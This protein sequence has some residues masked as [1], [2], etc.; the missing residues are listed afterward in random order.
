VSDFGTVSWIENMRPAWWSDWGRALDAIGVAPLPGDAPF[1]DRPR[2]VLAQGT[3]LAGTLDGKRIEVA[4][5]AQVTVRVPIDPPLDLG[6]SIDPQGVF[7]SHARPTG[8]EAFDALCSILADEPTRAGALVTRPVTEAFMEL[9][10]RSLVVTLR[11]DVVTV[12]GESEG[13]LRM[14]VPLAVEVVHRID[15]GRAKLAV[16]AFLTAHRA[17]LGRLASEHLL[18]I[19]DTPIR[20]SGTVGAFRVQASVWRQWH[21]RFVLEASLRLADSL[22]LDLH[23]EPADLL[24][25]L[26]ALLPGQTD[27]RVGDPEFDA[28]FYVRTSAPPILARSLDAEARR[29]LVACAR[30]ARSVVLDDR[31]LTLALPLRRDAPA[32]PAD[33]LRGCFGL[34]DRL[35]AAVRSA[36][37]GPAAG[38]FR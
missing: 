25:P 21:E 28:A 27:H 18:T 29:V 11:D 10:R 38:P 33:L 26:R 5:G 37:S 31:G 8:H 20:F 17:A 36:P 15:G 13:W 30:A 9:M 1:A 32:E 16:P 35:S 34:V 24:T 6:L 3:R 23:V 7:P 12:I 2:G 4:L 19:D 14:A 22:N